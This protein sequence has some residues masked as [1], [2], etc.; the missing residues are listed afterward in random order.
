MNKNNTETCFQ[1]KFSDRILLNKKNARYTGLEI[2]DAEACN[3]RL[4]S[5][6]P[7]FLMHAMKSEEKPINATNWFCVTD[8]THIQR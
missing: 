5:L 3:Y 6:T 4:Y 1:S 7:A 2:F 8:P